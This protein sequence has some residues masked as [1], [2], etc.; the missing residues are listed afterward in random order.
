MNEN[1]IRIANSPILWVIC[2]ITVIITLV[3]SF[4]YIRLSLKTAKKL[5]MPIEKCKKAFKSGL[6]TSIGPSMGVFIVMVGMMSVIGGPLSWMRLS[7]IGSAPTELTA[8]KVGAE[9]MG[10]TFGGADY[11]TTALLVGW[12]TMTLNGIGWLLVVGLFTHKLESIRL[13]LGGSDSKWLLVL[14][15]AA[16]L[17]AYGYLNSG[18]IVKGGG[19]LIA[20]IGGAFGMI[21]ISKIASKHPKLKEYTLGIAMLI[22]MTA[23]ILLS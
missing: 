18:D 11:N 7:I 12:L 15:G 21:T 16:M 8:A 4:L 13:K 10:I 23:A 5:N 3:Q 17:G 22:G 14:S 6:I 20:V 1:I 2:S 19:N 9:A